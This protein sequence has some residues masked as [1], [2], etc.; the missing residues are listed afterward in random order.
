M[1]AMGITMGSV[2]SRAH[3]MGSVLAVD[4]GTSSVRASI[5]RA[6]GS[7]VAQVASDPP[8]DAVEGTIDLHRLWAD[9]CAAITE[10]VGIAG[11]PDA[12]AVAAQLGT[13]FLDEALQ[14]TALALS[15]QH[16][17]AV[18]EADRLSA[19]LGDRALTIAGRRP[20]P[21]HAARPGRAGSRRRRP[22]TGRAPAGSSA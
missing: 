6:D 9:L 3:S 22:T 20:S 14:P 2:P 19:S 18:A 17:S 10:V 13:A 8:A 1:E 5:L 4:I 15:W 16:R 21:E 7:I 11:H 12:V